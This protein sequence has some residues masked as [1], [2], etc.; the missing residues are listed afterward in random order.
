MV[1]RISVALNLNYKEV[2]NEEAAPGFFSQLLG[3][4][5]YPDIQTEALTPE[6]L[7]S[8]E[9]LVKASVGFVPDRDYFSINNFEF[10]PAISKQATAALRSGQMIE[11][12]KQWT[13]WAMQVLVFIVFAFI[14]VRM[15]KRF[16][17]PIL[18]QAQ[19]E[20]PVLAPA[21][22][23]GTPKTVAELES[24]LDGELM[25]MVSPL[26]VTKAEIMKKRVLEFIKDE[27][28]TACSLVRTWIM[29]EE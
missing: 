27:P 9:S 16:V 12:L 13:P 29:E 22:P 24:E 25:E 17:V 14:A 11:H 19:L 8:I 18:E 7:E 1:T 20:E 4:N 5:S 23:S 2:V 10:K 26:E 15:F 3:S 21:L 6:A 28:E